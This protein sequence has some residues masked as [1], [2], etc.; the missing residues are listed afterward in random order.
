MSIT[1]TCDTC[2][3][4]EIMEG[5]R[6][7]IIRK[8][9][10]KKGWSVSFGSISKCPTCSHHR[11]YGEGYVFLRNTPNE[12]KRWIGGLGNVR[13]SFSVN[14]WGDDAENKAKAF[15]ASLIKNK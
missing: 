12:G 14:K 9:L 15:R 3:T 10:R 4:S 1:A 13:R 6:L 8:K 5:S 2:G 11:Q 7:G